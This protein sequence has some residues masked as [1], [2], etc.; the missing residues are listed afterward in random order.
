MGINTLESILN[1]VS[2]LVLEDVKTLNY[3]KTILCFLVLKSPHLKHK[4]N[5]L[6]SKITSV[7]N[8]YLNHPYLIDF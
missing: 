5:A 1:P 3:S 2:K 7:V 4:N 8:F 6:F